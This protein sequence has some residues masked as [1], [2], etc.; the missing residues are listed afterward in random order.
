MRRES[1][2]SPY[3][4]IPNRSL[5]MAS[6]IFGEGFQEE[7]WLL[8]LKRI[9]DP[10]KATH[11]SPSRCQ[12]GPRSQCPSASSGKCSQRCSPEGRQAEQGPVGKVSSSLNTPQMSE[13]ETLPQEEQEDSSSTQAVCPVATETVFVKH[14]CG[15]WVWIQEGPIGFISSLYSLTQQRCLFFKALRLH[16]LK[17]DTLGT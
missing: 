4:Q 14:Q 9:L 13:L 12:I 10:P 6:D 5:I 1:R 2:R 11:P 8:S 3:W 7:D 17:V 15:C 16:S